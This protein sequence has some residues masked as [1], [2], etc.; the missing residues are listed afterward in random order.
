MGDIDRVPEWEDFQ[1]SPKLIYKYNNVILSQN[2]NL[3]ISQNSSKKASGT[4]NV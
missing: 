4:I 2:L 3:L 1:L